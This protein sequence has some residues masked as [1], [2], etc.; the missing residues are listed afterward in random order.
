MD[1]HTQ[2]PAF[3]FQRLSTRTSRTKPHRSTASDGACGWD[4]SV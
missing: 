2:V 3:A 1:H 4:C